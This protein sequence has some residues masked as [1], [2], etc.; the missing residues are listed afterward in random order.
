MLSYIINPKINAVCIDDNPIIRTDEIIRSV[1]WANSALRS[2]DEATKAFDINVFNTLGM[3][4]LS[5]MVGEVFAKSLLRNTNQKLVENLHQDGYPDL[6]LVD[7]KEKLDYYHTLFRVEGNKKYPYS[8]RDF[9]PFLYGGIE[10][11]AT[12]G[13][14][15]TATSTVPKPLIGEQRIQIMSAFD[16][17]AHHRDTN[18]LLA[19]LWD[20]ISEVPTIVAVFYRNDLTL[21]DWGRI[22]QP[23][24]GGGRTTSVSI[25]TSA[26][27]AKMCQGWLA[28]IDDSA[29]VDKLAARKW[30]GR[31]VSIYRHQSE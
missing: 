1:N 6:L 22:V 15:P 4:N 21:E 3:R 16:W 5:G 26:G 8:K 7:S 30:I 23:K 10:V 19:I 12:C 9:S 20:F 17:K 27:V 29:Y 2:I 13:S 25:M 31:N 24:E 28:V 11:K 14:T 18:N